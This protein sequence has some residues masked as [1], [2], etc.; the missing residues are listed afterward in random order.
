MLQ[1]APRRVPGQCRG[2]HICKPPAIRGAR[3]VC[4]SGRGGLRARLTADNGKAPEAMAFSTRPVTGTSATSLSPISS[5]AS[6]VALCA[7]A[8]YGL[9]RLDGAAGTLFSTGLSNAGRLAKIGCDAS[10][11]RVRLER[12]ALAG[13]QAWECQWIV[14]EDGWL[15]S[16][17]MRSLG[18]SV[19]VL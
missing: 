10:C 6:I 8:G 12:R 19:A 16:A 18:I 9:V 13:L 3:I 1:S 2:P 5:D 11:R 17:G 7:C 15:I 4:G 14:M